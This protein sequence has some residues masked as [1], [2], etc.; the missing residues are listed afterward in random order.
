VAKIGQEPTVEYIP[1]KPTQHMISRYEGSAL[2]QKIVVLADFASETGRRH[3]AK[4]S[5]VPHGGMILSFRRS[6]ILSLKVKP[7]IGLRRICHETN[8]LRLRRRDSNIFSRETQKV[9]KYVAQADKL[10]GR[11]TNGRKLDSTQ[12]FG[13]K[14]G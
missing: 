4:K 11:S 9:E 14:N 1:N 8:S 6:F 13:G 3:G 2:I 7:I 10:K 5:H 12:N